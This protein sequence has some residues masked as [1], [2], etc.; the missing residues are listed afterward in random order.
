[1]N[2]Y[3][4]IRGRQFDLLALR[5]AVEQDGLA[6]NIVPVIEP[7]KD[8]PALTAVANAFTAQRHPLFVIQNPQVGSFGLL[9]RPVHAIA[10]SEWVQPARYFDGRPAPLIIA[11]TLAQAVALPRTQLCLIP[12]GARFRRL[13]L[14]QAA[15]LEDH[16]PTRDHTE[17]YRLVQREFYQYPASTLPG[18]GFADY[19]LATRHFEEHGYPQRA[20]SLHLLVE[21][22]QALWVQH[23]TSVNNADFSAP[24]T[25]FFEAAAP[26][27]AW[28]HAHPQAATPALKSLIQLAA[29]QHFPG[30]GGLRKLQ[31]RHF[32][33]IMGRYLSQ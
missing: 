22:D 33:T 10:W 25:K 17:D 20:L 12:S 27:P 21:R 24:Q 1:M 23:F 19:P 29:S 18:A 13:R 2:Y 11:E 9:A 15:Y 26:L 28:L 4:L 3:P 32:L 16:T 30:A 8:L 7:I 5:E 31:M 14:P 6:Q